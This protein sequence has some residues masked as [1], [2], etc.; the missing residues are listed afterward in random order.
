[1]EAE[2][3]SWI[4][5]PRP[6][7]LS[8]AAFVAEYGELYEQSPWVAAMVADRRVDGS[9]DTIQGLHA[10]LAEAMLQA[11]PYQQLALI[12]AH[13]DLA[14]RAAVTADSASEQQSVGLNQCSPEQFERF[15]SL[16]QR[17][18]DQFGFPFIMAV[19]GSNRFLILEAF[20]TRIHH[21][22][23]TEF[24]TALAEINK[25]ALFR[26]FQRSSSAPPPAP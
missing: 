13:P 6:S 7:Q 16:N 10:A 1:M 26:L 9:L 2:K 14:T 4:L 17:Y 5:D 18:K 20:E 12:R 25:I 24:A 23:A 8:A 21:D 3:L 22:S 11:A 19:R 15:T